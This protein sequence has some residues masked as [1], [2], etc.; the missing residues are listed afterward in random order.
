MDFADKQFSHISRE[1]K[2]DLA[3]CSYKY[4]VDE[5]DSENSSKTEHF[6][7]KITWGLARDSDVQVRQKLSET[8]SA[9]EKLPLDLAEE[10]A[11]DVACVSAPFLTVT[12]AFTDKQMANL[13]PF[14]KEHAISILAQRPD[15]KAQTV[16]AIALAGEATSVTHLV[17]NKIIVLSEKTVQKILERFE[18]NQYLIDILA[19][20]LDLPPGTVKNII[21][22]VSDIA[23]SNLNKNYAVNGSLAAVKMD[24]SDTDWLH[25]QIRDADPHQ[26][27]SIAINLRQRGKLKHHQILQV[28]ELGFVPLL[29]S[30]LAL[31]AGETLGNVR[32]ILTLKDKA[33][34]VKL[35]QQAGFNKNLGPHVLRIVKKGH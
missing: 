22:L 11:S 4:F 29:E 12:D 21:G 6:V 26:I 25:S 9:C 30:T 5:W 35:L 34:F 1:T 18:D 19:S 31:E 2:F 7:E 3:V 27:H 23:L 13:V 10:I 28:A 8:L 16:Y 15:I 14:L 20:R 24:I 32:D 17:S 33:A